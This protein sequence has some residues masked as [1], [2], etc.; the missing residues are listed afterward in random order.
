MELDQKWKWGK[1]QLKCRVRPET[2][3]PAGDDLRE[4]LAELAGTDLNAL[5]G[6]MKLQKKKREEKDR[7]VSVDYDAVKKFRDVLGR[8]HIL[9]AGKFRTIRL[10]FRAK[11]TKR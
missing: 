6:E 11:S 7:G 4:R 2:G 8:S 9:G 3:N 5:L 10:P 1:R